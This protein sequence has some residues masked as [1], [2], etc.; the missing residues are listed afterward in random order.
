MSIAPTYFPERDNVDAI[1]SAP[2]TCWPP[3]ISGDAYVQLSD[4]LVLSAH[5]A[6]AYPL[7]VSSINQGV[8][9]LSR[10]LDSQNNE[11]FATC[12]IALNSVSP[13]YSMATLSI[14][15]AMVFGDPGAYSGSGVYEFDARTVYLNADSTV[16]LYTGKVMSLV[17]EDNNK[18]TGQVTLTQG[19]GAVITGNNDNSITISFPF[20]TPTSSPLKYLVIQVFN[21]TLVNVAYDNGNINLDYSGA[22]LDAVCVSNKANELPDS[23]GNLPAYPYNPAADDPPASPIPVTPSSTIIHTISIPLSSTNGAV[24]IAGVPGPGYR[25]R[26]SVAKTSDSELTLSLSG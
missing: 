4:S 13:V 2:F 11:E 14:I 9:T 22:S 5:V 20:P 24:T 10:N 19:A 18:A 23:D 21:N 16:P 15:G 3:C 6:T 17:D 26:L 12:T 1:T 8:L 7:W 25:S